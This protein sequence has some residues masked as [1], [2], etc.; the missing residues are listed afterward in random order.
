M[1]GRK[2]TTLLDRSAGQLVEAVLVEDVSRAELVEAHIDW[3]PHRLEALKRA[4]EG[5]GKWPE[6]W[7]WDWSQKAEKLKFLAYRCFGVE[8]GGQMQGLM[9]VSTI[10]R[11]ARI[12][13]EGGKPVLY[14]EYIESAPWNLRDLTENPRFSGVGVAL[15]EAAIG[16]SLREGMGGRIGLHSLPQSEAF[17]GRYME[18]LGI[19][20]NRDEKLRYFEMTP[21][22]ARAFI[23]GRQR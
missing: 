5:R 1:S 14:I 22:Q 3:Q 20:S 8:Y 4:A 2:P 9:M 23:E 6:H 12:S 13:T 21:E 7:H 18:D 19:D 16:L 15:L 11:R 17:Y 10:G